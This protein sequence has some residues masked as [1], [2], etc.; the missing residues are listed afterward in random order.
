LILKNEA[1]SLKA[2]LGIFSMFLCLHIFLIRDNLH[3]IL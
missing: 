2:L 1:K 3:L